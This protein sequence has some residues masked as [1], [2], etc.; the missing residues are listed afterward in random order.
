MVWYE[1]MKESNCTATSTR[2]SCDDEREMAFTHR[3]FGKDG[4]G[5]TSQLDYILGPKMASNQVFKHIDVKLWDTWNH[6]L[7]H[8]M[9]QEGYP[10]T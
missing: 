3:P 8:A 2:S 5:T 10:Q 1:T 4:V 9:I 7:M 6:Y